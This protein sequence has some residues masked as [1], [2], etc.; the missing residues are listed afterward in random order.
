MTP[1][2]L[3]AAAGAWLAE[4]AVLRAQVSAAVPPYGSAPERFSEA[5]LTV[6]AIQDRVEELQRLAASWAATAR[7]WATEAADAEED[8]FDRECA[9][10]KRMGRRDE[11]ASSRE[12][13]AQVSPKIM[14]Y[15]RQTRSARRLRDDLA[16][17]LESVK[18]AYQGIDSTRYDLGAVL[19]HLEWEKSMER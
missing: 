3:C 12:R 10:Q 9:V 17:I 14:E 13:Q 2:E 11:Y 18:S 8:A 1:E 15:K 5:L 16:A 4:V 7:A 19:R 6:R